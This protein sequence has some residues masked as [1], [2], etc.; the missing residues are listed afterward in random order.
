PL[1]P[2]ELQV[3]RAQ[4][5]KEG[6]YVGIQTKFNYAW[7][8]IKSNTRPDQQEGVRLLS[9]IFRGA[10][11]RR[12][13]CLYYLALGNYKLGNYGEARRYNDLLLEKEPANL[14][15]ASLG[16]L[17]DDKVAK[18]GLMGIAIVGGLAVAAGVVGSLIVKGARRR[19]VCPH[20]ESDFTEIV[21]D[22]SSLFPP[23]FPSPF[24]FPPPSLSNRCF[25]LQIEIP[26]ESPQPEHEAELHLPQV[27][28]WAD[29]NPWAHEEP[30]R[31]QASGWMESGAPGYSHR[32]YRSPDGR[33]TFSSTTIGGGYSSRQDVQPNPMLPLMVQSLDTLFRGLVGTQD[34][35]QTQRGPGMNDS[36]DPHAAGMREPD[37]MH[38]PFQAQDEH[39][40][41]HEGLFPRDANSPQDM[42]APLQSLADFVRF[43]TNLWCTHHRSLLEAFQGIGAGQRGASRNG[44]ENPFAML[45]ALMRNHD[46][47]YSQ[48]ELDRVISQ[49]IDQTQQ[50]NAPPPASDAAIRSLPKK[51]MTQEMMGSDGKAECSICMDPVELDTE[52][53]VLPCTHWF[54][55][56]CIQA[57]LS[58]HNT[59]PHCR[60]SIDLPEVTNTGTGS[61]ENPVVIPDSPPTSPQRQRRRSSPFT[62]RSMRSARSSISRRS[63][64]NSNPEMEVDSGTRRDS[65]SESSRGGITGWVW[66]R[67]GG[68]N[69][70]SS[71]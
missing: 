45:S 54:H 32:S 51:K 4:Y 7:G 57:W 58:Q 31:P 17:I 60:R 46:A 35:H 52:V 29:H 49:L 19:Q 38:D 62:S 37:V 53:T 70:S 65:R 3:L 10:P 22:I 8:L 33:F 16:S 18:E 26:P 1:K 48:E 30:T 40:R 9:E 25:L 5:E 56:D 63:S 44:A 27:N 71:N 14:Q 68:G 28:P 42:T 55:F 20:C 50:G 12:R 13:E 6:E 67:L 66:S 69:S 15:A 36:H 41:R 64:Q 24:S 39:A 23:G 11:E 43:I 61:S 2:A 47:V 21:C 59:C 34:I